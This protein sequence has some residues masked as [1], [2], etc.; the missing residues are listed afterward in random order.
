[1]KKTIIPALLASMM[2]VGCKAQVAPTKSS[3]ETPRIPE[4]TITR[5]FYEENIYSLKFFDK[6]ANFTA[7]NTVV[8]DK[9]TYKIMVKADNGEY[10]VDNKTTKYHAFYKIYDEDENG[11]YIH[12]K[13]RDNDESS[14]DS[15]DEYLTIKNMI[16]EM[17]VL[18]P[19]RF[20]NMTYNEEEH[21]YDTINPFAIHPSYTSSM[22][23]A[24]SKAFFEDNVLVKSIVVL[25]AKNGDITTLTSVYSNYGKTEVYI[26]A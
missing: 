18:M 1:M 10:E 23:L 16:Y 12:F 11:Y 9:Q 19:A 5:E 13:Y 21:C 3:S 4:Y 25:T 2:L 22:T 6:T 17:G 14:Y 20:D 7:L 15:Q 26:P 24:S 8:Y